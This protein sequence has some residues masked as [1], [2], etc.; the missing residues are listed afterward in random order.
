MSSGQVF[1][2]VGKVYPSL[3]NGEVYSEVGMHSMSHRFIQE[4][5]REATDRE[6]Y[7]YLL[8]EFK[9]VCGGE[10]YEFIGKD[11]NTMQTVQGI[12]DSRYVHNDVEGHWFKV[13][14]D[15]YT[16]GGIVYE[17]GT[18]FSL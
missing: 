9:Y 18:W 4:N 12:S 13:I 15:R 5:F 7:S 17:N 16:E 3:T 6:I 14:T 1:A 10:G 2:K 8:E 11:G